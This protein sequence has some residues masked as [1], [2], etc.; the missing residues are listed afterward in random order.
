M[1]LNQQQ[2]LVAKY[3]YDPFGNLLSKAGSLAD[4]NVYRFSSKQYHSATGLYYYGL[5]W[6]DPN[7]QRWMNRD[8]I[9]EDG[10]L[11]LYR[12]VY[13]NPNSWF[14]ADGLVPDGFTPPSGGNLYQPDLNAFGYNW[15]TFFQ[16]L[17]EQWLEDQRAA[18]DYGTWNGQPV[19]GG[20][21]P[22]PGSAG[23]GKLGKKTCEIVN[24]LSQRAKRRLAKALG[25]V[26]RS[27]QPI[28]QG[29]FRTPGS[30][31]A[32]TRWWEYKDAGDATKIII[33]HPDDTVHVGIPKPQSPHPNGPP[34]YYPV[35]GT[36]HVGE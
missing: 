19:L 7:L 32:G 10:G 28:R 34:K 29:I 1:I 26:P 17:W 15:P 11:N 35:P 4:A 36:G 12:F 33:E 20:T 24:S 25:G 9:G 8:P 31:G 2:V 30:S 3:T 22:L 27:A 16:A 21:P 14:D 18:N 23:L 5:R 6:Y 13:N